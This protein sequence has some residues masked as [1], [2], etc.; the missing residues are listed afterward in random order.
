MGSDGG[1]CRDDGFVDPT[2]SPRNNSEATSVADMK[3]SAWRGMIIRG[4][5]L[6][7]RI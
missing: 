7:N 2:N 4:K 5:K 6:L 1:Q 3:V